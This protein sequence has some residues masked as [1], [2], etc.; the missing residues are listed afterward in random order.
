[1]QGQFRTATSHFVP[2]KAA[3]CDTVNFV[4]LMRIDIIFY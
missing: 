2:T 4:W 3:V 1:M